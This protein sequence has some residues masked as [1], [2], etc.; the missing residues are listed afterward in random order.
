MSLIDFA[1]SGQLTEVNSSVVNKPL[2]INMGETDEIRRLLMTPFGYKNIDNKLL[3]RITLMY[4]PALH[5]ID[6]NE[7]NSQHYCGKIVTIDEAIF[8]PD[9]PPVPRP[10]RSWPEAFVMIFGGLQGLEY[11]SKQHKKRYVTEHAYNPDSVA[12]N[13]DRLATELM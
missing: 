12:D 6:W 3:R 11:E 9:L 1:N 7:Y 2:M 10:Y 5:K 8:L 13:R 4:V